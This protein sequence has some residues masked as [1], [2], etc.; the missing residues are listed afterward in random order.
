MKVFIKILIYLS[1]VASIACF[2]GA[3][4]IYMSIEDVLKN[5]LTRLELIFKDYT[6]DDGYYIYVTTETK[7]YYIPSF[8]DEIDRDELRL[9]E[10]GDAITLWIEERTSHNHQGIIY[11]LRA[12][13]SV[14]LSIDD[15][16]Q[17][18]RTN[19]ILGVI[20]VSVFG[21]VFLGIFIYQIKKP[22]LP[23]DDTF[24]LE[25]FMNQEVE[26]KDG[27]MHVN[28]DR[29]QGDSFEETWYEKLK[30]LQIMFLYDDSSY[31]YLEGILLFKKGKRLMTM[32]LE[33]LDGFYQMDVSWLSYHYPRFRRMS[34]E[35]IKIFL[36]LLKDYIHETGIN[37]KIN[38]G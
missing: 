8:I 19:S 15:Y 12:S 3:Y 24:D 11:E 35:D 16:N 9:L 28:H 5:D 30:E 38:E 22:I 20:L 21:V 27:F 6:Y 26:I 25:D 31:K 34:K 17:D 18:S 36:A 37:I 14:I 32:F 13:N 23:Y 29:Y 33:H 7:P 10:E 2:I 1:L 4:F